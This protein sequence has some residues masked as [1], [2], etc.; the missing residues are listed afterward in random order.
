MAKKLSKERKLE[1]E[2]LWVAAFLF[3]LVII[4]LGASA[5]FRSLHT[6]KYEGL[7]FTEE[8]FGQLPVYHY[9]YFFKNNKN[10]LIKYNLYLQTDPREN[11]VTTSGNKISFTRSQVFVTVDPRGIDSCPKSFAA[12]FDISRFLSENDLYVRN[13]V[14][15][16]G[17]AVILNQSYVTC[18]TRPQSDVIEIF[19]SDEPSHIVVNGTCY[20]IIVGPECNIFDAVEK[21]KLRSV[22]D[23][24]DINGTVS[25]L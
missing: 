6:F 8:K 22:L 16:Y 2:L 5:Y 10:N 1:Q 13:T 19:H 7:T 14:M 3:A 18:K 21:F 15:D 12:I 9:S 4:F 25:S 23:A 11:N 24:R 20:Q 17:N